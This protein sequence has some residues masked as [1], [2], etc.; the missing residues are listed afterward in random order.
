MLLL[1]GHHVFCFCGIFSCHRVFNYALSVMPDFGLLHL[2]GSRAEGGPDAT[3]HR[4]SRKRCYFTC[5]V[6]SRERERARVGDQRGFLSKAWEQPEQQRCRCSV[7]QLS[8]FCCV[9]LL[10]QRYRIPPPM[11]IP[12]N[13]Y[14]YDTCTNNHDTM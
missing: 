4:K 2:G 13:S 14:R 5:S 1:S 7:S 3:G 6:V 12:H 8:T 10:Q 11:I 9:F